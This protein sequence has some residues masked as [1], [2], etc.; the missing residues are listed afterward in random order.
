PHHVEFVEILEFH[1]VG[2]NQ[3]AAENQ[4]EKLLRMLVCHC[5]ALGLTLEVGCDPHAPES[6]GAGR[7]LRRRWTAESPDRHCSA[8]CDRHGWSKCRP[9][10]AQSGRPRPCPS[11][12]WP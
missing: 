5:F 8:E 3:F 4:M 1:L 12:A 11:P 2:G 7:A 9:P 6:A 10:R